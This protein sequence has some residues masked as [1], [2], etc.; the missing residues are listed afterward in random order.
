MPRCRG[1]AWRL[2]ALRP[3]NADGQTDL[4]CLDIG[5]KVFEIKS[6]VV[7]LLTEEWIKGIMKP[8]DL[9]FLWLSD[10]PAIL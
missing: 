9:N 4:I 7:P 6:P 8:H 2:P 10:L 5:Y 1:G 3:V